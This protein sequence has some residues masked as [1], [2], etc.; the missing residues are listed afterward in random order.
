MTRFSPAAALLILSLIQPSTISA[1]CDQ[2]QRYSSQYRSSYTDLAV[3][4]NDL[5]ATTIYGVELLDRSSGTPRILGSLGLRG[6]TSTVVSSPTLAYVGS[7]SDIVV[8]RRSLPLQATR[9]VNVGATVNDLLYLP[10]Y[11]YAATQ[12]GVVQ[13]DLFAPESPV[14]AR[15]LNT[16]SGTANSLARLDSTLYAADG[17][18][19]VEAFSIS[20]PSLPQKI[21]VFNSLPRSIGV[22]AAGGRLFV[23]DGQQTEIFTG[24]GAQ[25]S[26]VVTLSGVGGTS[27]FPAV[28][29]IHWMSGTDRRLRAID[30]AE[31]TAPVV[32][33][34]AATPATAGSVNRVGTITGS[35]GLLYVAAGDGGLRTINAAEFRRP[36]PIRSIPTAPLRTIATTATAIF[37]SL[38][39]GGILRG[40][41]DGG[42]FTPGVTFDAQTRQTIADI[43][44]GRL[45]T[46]AGSSITLWNV[47]GDAIVASRA[48]L[49]TS[50]ISAIL[51]GTDAYAVLADRTLHKVNLSA[52]IGT[53]SNVTPSGTRPFFIAREGSRIATA[54]VSDE[55][56]TTLR[57]H[58]ADLSVIREA[59]IDGAATGGIALSASGLIASST[60]RG[61]TIFDGISGELRVLAE[62]SGV[63][64]RDLRFRGDDL[65]VVTRESML[66]WKARENQRIA[67]VALPP[68]AFSIDVIAS[69]GVAAIATTAGVVLVD[70]A[71]LAALPSE[72]SAIASERFYTKQAI[73]GSTLYLL[74][75]RRVEVFR[76]TATSLSPVGT[77]SSSEAIVDL[78]AT[79]NKLVVLSSNGK[80]LTYDGASP[81]PS[82]ELTISEGDDVIFTSL[83]SA[84]R[85]V[86][87]SL[88]K[89]CLSGM[90]ERKTLVFDVATLTQTATMTGA[91][92]D[93]SVD[94]TTGFAVVD[95]PS[96]LRILNL[97]D[98]LRPSIVRSRSNVDSA[99]FA[100]IVSLTRTRSGTL[101]GAGRKLYLFSEE[102]FAK[103]GELLD[104]YVADPTG[105]ITILDQR[106][107]L[108][109][110]CLV[111]IGRSHEPLL[112][113]VNAAGTLTAAGTFR[114]FAAVR[115]VDISASTFHFL[116]DYSV[117]VWSNLIAPPALRKR[118]GRR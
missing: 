37:A 34:E 29:G 113:T 111:L 8:V 46:Y 100:G 14:V 17:D 76:A 53:S 110:D 1:A 51:V 16:T 24:N 36:F 86:Y 45:L 82:R 70:S 39:D 23:S 101:V 116:T 11:L 103:T 15:T 43:D 40:R 75:G 97:A 85:A 49:A 102:S 114:S 77:I 69:S 54:E 83:H 65:Y 5:W 96:E 59:V 95:L 109:G 20:V 35:S 21:G 27:V 47:T 10:P 73:T 99:E 28:D 117:D 98:P 68:D 87:V 81:A 33:Y 25:M 61:V 42:A 115:E 52:A 104:P 78:T 6:A 31:V 118:S 112:F 50:V 105:R 13:L 38:E 63:L 22:N 12:K 90:C 2:T 4:G 79:D 44:G 56:R 71:R 89:G 9:T 26:R 66:V 106:V 91:I 93:L 57:L 19:S 108:I 32:V 41:L 94:G 67:N 60:F 88:S 7:G 62:S 18:S 58:A 107:R 80:L 84:G 30:L 72:Q 92:V 3:E 64:A 55:G 48:V 74:D